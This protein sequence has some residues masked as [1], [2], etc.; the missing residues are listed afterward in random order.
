MEQFK[1]LLEETVESVGER[2]RTRQ[3]NEEAL[4]DT[5]FDHTNSK[6]PGLTGIEKKEILNP[7]KGHSVKERAFLLGID[8]NRIRE[9]IERE[10]PGERLEG[11]NKY[12]ALNERRYENLKVRESQEEG[13]TRLQ[14]IKK[15]LKENLVGLSVVGIS[16]AGIITT[17]IMAGSKALVKRGQALGTFEKTWGKCSKTNPLLNILAM[18]LNWAIKE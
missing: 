18:V 16:I 8:N 12:L 13:I 9:N 6:F 2:K 14:K 3:D 5:N 10:K 4:I 1:T 11:L 7:P 15:W 17:I